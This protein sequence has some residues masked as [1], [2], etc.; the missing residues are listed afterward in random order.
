VDKP[1]ELDKQSARRTFGKAAQ[2]YDAAAVLQHEVGRRMLERLDYVKLQP[3]R[4]LDVGCGTG[5]HTEALL[6]RYPKAEVLGL[7]FAMPMLEQTRKRGRWLRRAKCLC[8]DLDSLP[9]AAHSVDLVFS[10][11]AIQWSRD[12]AGAI[13]E[14]HRVLRPGG[15]LMFSSFGPDTLKELRQA[16]SLVDGE[17]HVHGF[18]DMHHYGDMMVQAGFA[19]PVMDMQHLCLTYQ[20]VPDLMRDL[21]AVGAN[22]AS[23][24]RSRTL[25][26]K[27]RLQALK[28]AYEQFRDA[29][30][31]L[32]ATYEVVY[33]H[34]WGAQQ[35]RAGNEVHV[36]LDVLKSQ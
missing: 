7:D 29:E 25:T 2:S 33:G 30:G 21:K 31:R 11:A 18:V 19:D 6:K 32:P 3:Q 24:G 26:G 22:N 14:L 10:N 17:E 13:A 12:P 16:W 8:G 34:A 20:S 1:F 23:V 15:L 35:R 4:V 9:L 27:A 36:S 28:S 5:L